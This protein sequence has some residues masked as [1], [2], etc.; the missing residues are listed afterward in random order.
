MQ[1]S[2]DT[3]LRRGLSGKDASST[4]SPGLASQGVD[5]EFDKSQSTLVFSR[6]QSGLGSYPAVIA[7]ISQSRA[8]SGF[9]VTLGLLRLGGSL[10]G[11]AKILLPFTLLGM[12]LQLTEHGHGNTFMV[13]GCPLK[14]P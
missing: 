10:P 9:Q 12:S 3:G 6:E 2:R 7:T 8:S 4:L 11:T 5:I 1:A 13:G 14:E